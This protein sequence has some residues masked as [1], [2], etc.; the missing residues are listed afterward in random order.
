MS[1][2]FYYYLDSTPTHSYCK[3]LYKYPQQAYPYQE[4]IEEN[5]RRSRE[6]REYELLDT[7]IF[8]K[9]EYFDVFAEYAKNAPDDIL[10]RLTIAN[11]SEHDAPLHIIPTLFFRNTWSWGCKH[12]GCTMRPKIEQR[13]GEDFLRTKHDVLEPFLFDIHPDENGQRPEVLFTDNQTNVKLLYQ[14]ENPSPYVKDAFH[15]YVIHQRKDAV[16]PKRKGTK[17]GLYYRLKVPGKASTRLHLRLHRAKDD[18]SP[19]SKLDVA[20]I[21]KLFQKRIDEADKFYSIVLNPKLN[22]DE[23]NI[24]RQGYAGLLYTKQFYHYI[25]QDWIEGDA[26]IMLSSENRKKS[27]RNKDWSHL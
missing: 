24:V 1:K 16:N 26:D 12:E 13:D 11:R 9:N 18:G 20:G 21:E 22:D 25:V 19:T 23:R 6:D 8:D 14:T 7:H 4:L 2:N 5:R 3:S 17:V 27:A 10:I 15:D